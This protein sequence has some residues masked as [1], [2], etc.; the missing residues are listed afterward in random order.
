ME[1]KWNGKWQNMKHSTEAYGDVHGFVKDFVKFLVEDY[2][3]LRGAEVLVVFNGQ[4]GWQRYFMN[5]LKEFLKEV[6]MEL[7]AENA[8]DWATE[9]PKHASVF[10]E[11]VKIFKVHPL[12][13]YKDRC[14][15][16]DFFGFQNGL[17]VVVDPYELNSRRGSNYNGVFM[18]E[19][20]ERKKL[21]LMPLARTRPGKSAV[22]FSLSVDIG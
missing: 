19:M 16:R 6:F 18:V 17:R 1:K 10:T 22:A 3:E 13:G 9:E 21:R 7:N 20:P 15:E 5:T 14:I 2:G 4:V 12:F 11:N 8:F